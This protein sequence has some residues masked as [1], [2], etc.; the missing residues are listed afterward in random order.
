MAVARRQLVVVAV[1][2]L[3]GTVV[4]TGM[5]KSVVVAVERLSP[6]PRYLK[7]VKK[8]ERFIA[9][10]EDNSCNIGDYVRLSGTRP[11]SKTKRFVVAEVLRKV[12]DL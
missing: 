7:R 12:E 6:H 5:T 1:Q 10:D 8:T 4:S 3:K 9:H 2:D 11:L